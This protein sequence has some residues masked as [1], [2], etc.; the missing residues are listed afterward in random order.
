MAE[1][2]NN[3]VQK[4]GLDYKSVKKLDVENDK[5]PEIAAK[6]AALQNHGNELVIKNDNGYYLVELQDSVKLNEL[7]SKVPRD[8]KSII[9]INFTET[10]GAGAL[11]TPETMEGS[12]LYDRGKEIITSKRQDETKGFRI[13]DGYFK[14][15]LNDIN[16]FSNKSKNDI[17]L[18]VNGKLKITTE[19][20][21][22]YLNYEFLAANSKMHLQVRENGDNWKLHFN[23]KPE[24]RQEFRDHLKGLLNGQAGSW[25]DKLGKKINTDEKIVE[26]SDKLINGVEK[27]LGMSLSK[28]RISTILT[29]VTD[30][31]SEVP[32]LFNDGGTRDYIE[33][34]L[35]EES[36]KY[37][38][39]IPDYVYHKM[40]EFIDKKISSYIKSNYDQQSVN[41]SR[42]FLNDVKETL[43]YS[44]SDTELDKLTTVVKSNIKGNELEINLNIKGEI[45]SDKTIASYSAKP[46][47]LKTQGFF[48]LTSKGKAEMLSAVVN[49]DA[50]IDTSR[51]NSATV[52][53]M[54]EALGAKGEKLNTEL[55][56]NKRKINILGDAEFSNLNQGTYNSYM[57]IKNFREDNFGTSFKSINGFF[58][59]DVNTPGVL[60]LKSDGEVTVEQAALLTNYK[61]EP[62]ETIEKFVLKKPAGSSD[63]V[64]IDRMNLEINND[65]ASL[66]TEGIHSGIELKVKKFKKDISVDIKQVDLKEA[67]FKVNFLED[68]KILVDASGNNL[69][70]TGINVTSGKDK[71]SIGKITV[72][73]GKGKVELGKS[74]EFYVEGS[75]ARLEN[76]KS[77]GITANVVTEGMSS[78]RS[79]KESLHISG[80]VFKGNIQYKDEKLEFVCDKGNL[81][82]S[83][84]G[85]KITYKAGADADGAFTLKSAGRDLSARLI[86]PKGSKAEVDLVK[87][88][89]KITG[90]NSKEIDARIQVT[91]FSGKP[92][93]DFRVTSDEPVNTSLDKALEIKTNST[94]K[95][96]GSFKT[97]DGD[98]KFKG[99]FHGSVKYD[100]NTLT[101]STKAEAPETVEIEAMGKKF[102]L[103]AT[104]QAVIAVDF[105]ENK[106]P[107]G[108]RV[109]EAGAPV[110]VK[111][112]ISDVETGVVHADFETKLLNKTGLGFNNI[113]QWDENNISLKIT[114]PAADPVNGTPGI[115]I[116]GKINTPDG[117]VNINR[118][119]VSGVPDAAN[120]IQ[121]SDL[122]FSG[123]GVNFA[124]SEVNVDGSVSLEKP[125]EKPRNINFKGY[126]SL[127]NGSVDFADKTVNLSGASFSGKINDL[128]VKIEGGFDGKKKE[129]TYTGAVSNAN[130]TIRMNGNLSLVEY[131]KDILSLKGRTSLSFSEGKGKPLYFIAGMKDLKVYRTDSKKII[132]GS[133]DLNTARVAEN[134]IYP[135]QNLAFSG[136]FSLDKS[137]SGY[138][139][140]LSKGD[141][142]S[143]DSL[144]TVVAQLS[145][146]L[147]QPHISAELAK[148]GIKVSDLDNLQ[149]Q[150]YSKLV[151]AGLKTTSDIKVNLDNDLNVKNLAFN[152]KVDSLAMN[153]PILRHTKEKGF[154]VEAKPGEMMYQ[155]N[156][157]VSISGSVSDTNQVKTKLNINLNEILPKFLDQQFNSSESPFKGKLD[158]KLEGDKIKI[159]DAHSGYFSYIS[160]GLKDI[161]VKVADNKAEVVLKIEFLRALW[162]TVKFALSSDVKIKREWETMT[163]ALG[164]ANFSLKDVLGSHKITLDL[165][166]M[167]EK[168]TPFKLDGTIKLQDGNLEVP[169]HN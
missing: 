99:N 33:K 152:T 88:T 111:L 122:T 53:S 107:L 30:A 60:K 160:F 16:G 58:D 142:S 150:L 73:K 131:N 141:L 43:G 35:K 3:F 10:G 12:T 41:N 147:K 116:K 112:K 22:D 64:K 132:S 143:G 76:L 137:D 45:S 139:F 25:R 67:D 90:K 77:M 163:K 68:K 159:S 128:N 115:S 164:P 5:N 161:D 83:P 101:Y 59:V 15:E 165:P 62:G 71:L 155:L 13:G 103:E 14:V 169:L 117:S 148:K 94:V 96:D 27:K 166:Q 151:S 18:N 17:T 146:V 66:H 36:G 7:I 84:S 125:G 118:L 113:R 19:D 92:I 61:I 2:V 91:T 37:E 29:G 65:S 126:T 158:I 6:Y 44:L 32:K 167:V 157:P 119:D 20:L 72:A 82:I 162:D 9:A 93:G 121:S 98:V 69:K 4:L 75:G 31:K 86:L 57:N 51:I 106:T 8:S 124:G 55:V 48:D 156:Q 74:G 23:L 154:S 79:S 149:K 54:A 21:T 78:I 38:E 85:N 50:D 145:A 46:D 120:N 1:S 140:N 134:K 114:P 24:V 97:K 81:D 135:D 109:G 133:I 56:D 110:D 40:A 100:E 105:A 123:T 130:E 108:L 138:V 104:N 49:A 47:S 127:K 28:E 95:V 144:K 129:A 87:N 89:L 11:Y 26:L 42:V 136:N 168:N 34:I 153:F 102:N 63:S 39:I 80:P 52:V 70:L